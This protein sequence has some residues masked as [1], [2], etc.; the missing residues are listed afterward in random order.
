MRADMA[1]LDVSSRRRSLIGY[2]AG[3]AAYSLVVV[4]LYPAFEH[5]SSLDEFVKSD[6]TAAALFGVTEPLSSSVG[7]LNGNIYANFFPLVLLL[8]TV[9]YGAASLAGQNDDGTL[10]L[11]ATLPVRRSRIV[12]EKAAAMVL[13]AVLVAA[14]VAACVLAGRWFDLT[15]TL[16]N[17]VSGSAAV[18]LMAVDFGLVA[19]AV[20]ALTGKR[21][22]A[23][24]VATFLAVTSYLLSSLAAVVSWLSPAKYLS[25]FYWSVG[26]DQ[27]GSGVTL[28]DY[29]V[30]IAVGVCALY[31]TVIAFR[32]LDLS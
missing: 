21:G 6:S 3:M 12:L 8:L 30:L 16:G 22:T 32:R 31:A 5:S 24:G 26:A 1:R 18:A 9:G 2:A 28:A 14:A 13:Q 11:L 4:A 29:A 25:L 20:G 27:I 10:C 19:M 7:W 15:V 23:I 17:A